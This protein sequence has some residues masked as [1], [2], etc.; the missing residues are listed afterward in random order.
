MKDKTNKRINI[1]LTNTGDLALKR[2]ARSIL[3]ELDLKS[4]DKIIDI[5]CGDG[6][7][8]HLLS[9]LGIKLKLTGIDL[10][11]DS[12]ELAKE[13]LKNK[14]IP[15]LKADLMKKLP[16]L[17]N[18]FDKA[19]MSEVAEHLPNDLKGLREVYRIIKPG[20]ILAL[21]VPHKNYPFL[22]DPVNWSLER[23]FKTHIKSG[24]WAGIWNQ[25]IRLYSKDQICKVLEKAGFKIE[26]AEVQTFWCLP[27]NHYLLNIGWRMLKAKV[28]SANL[29]C[30]VNKFQQVDPKDR[31]FLPKIY[32]N[33][34][35]FVDSFNKRSDITV[36]MTIFVKAEKPKVKIANDEKIFT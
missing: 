9:S 12:L 24:F 13:N 25:H 16:F 4:E 5:G 23:I 31:S 14:N 27:F 1:L 30:Q 22:W 18:T 32:F 19:V 11:E 33:V 36:G 20:G 28:L 35:E 7:Y 2:R 8:L 17:S 15:L 26:K 3:K 21:T 34:S 29:H 6:Y 10:N